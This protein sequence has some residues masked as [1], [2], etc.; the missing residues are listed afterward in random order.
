MFCIR[1]LKKSTTCETVT[2][3]L[4]NAQKLLTCITL[5]EKKQNIY[6]MKLVHKTFKTYL[7]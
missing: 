4:E 7:C 3:T 6:W 5:N 1:I 2:N